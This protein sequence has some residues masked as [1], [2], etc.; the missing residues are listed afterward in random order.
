MATLTENQANT[1]FDNRTS[2]DKA[3]DSAAVFET[4]LFYGRLDGM[5]YHINT[6]AAGGL[7]LDTDSTPEEIKTALIT[8]LQTME[9]L[10]SKTAA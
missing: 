7:G 3:C 9:Y 5:R 6:A 10:G 8:H 4:F 2:C 1:A